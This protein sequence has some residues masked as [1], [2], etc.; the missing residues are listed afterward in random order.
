MPRS[1]KS[2]GKR[3]FRKFHF[4]YPPTF[5]HLTPI[6]LTQLRSSRLILILYYIL[7]IMPPKLA[8]I[9]PR[10]PDENAQRPSR[11]ILG[12][13]VREILRKDIYTM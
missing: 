9:P 6:I 8:I 13:R 1:T 3:E 7:Y 11:T 2:G 12:R 10:Q 5:N 4:L